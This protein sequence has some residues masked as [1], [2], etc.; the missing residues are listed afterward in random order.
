MRDALGIDGADWAA[1]QKALAADA[2]PL[3]RLDVK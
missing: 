3:G 2:S 1:E